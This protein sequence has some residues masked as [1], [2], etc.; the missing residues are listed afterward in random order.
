MLFALSIAQLIV[1]LFLIFAIIL[2]QKGA[3][4]GG[5]FGGEGSLYSTRRGPERALFLTT[6][7]LAILFVGLALALIVA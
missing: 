6:V 3:G 5:A 4:L 2:Q 7:V 1:S